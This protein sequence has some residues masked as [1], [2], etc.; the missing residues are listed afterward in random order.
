MRRKAE[1]SLA[2]VSKRLRIAVIRAEYNPEI[3]RSLEAKCLEGLKEAGVLARQIECFTVP[4]CFEIPLLAQKLAARKRYAVL[5]AL[6]A[7]IR[8]ETI[9]FELVANECARGIMEVSLNHNVPIIF[10]VLA[11][12]KRGD[13]LR[14]AGNNRF[15]KGFEAAGAALSMLRTLSRIEE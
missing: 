3:T 11:A 12:E 15:N 9:H 7:I 1:K 4:G 13:A 14:R 2:D 8:G 10:E 5:I 6:G